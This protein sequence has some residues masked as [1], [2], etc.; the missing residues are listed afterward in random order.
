MLERPG[1][2]RLCVHAYVNKI[3]FLLYP[4]KFTPGDI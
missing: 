1:S 3:T 2:T 4:L